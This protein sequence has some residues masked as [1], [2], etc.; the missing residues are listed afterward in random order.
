[1]CHKESPVRLNRFQLNE[2]SLGRIAE[3]VQRRI[4]DFPHAL[5]WNANSRFA[6]W[7]QEQLKGFLNIHRG[8]RCFILANGPSLRSMDLSLLKGEITFGMNRIYLLAD[9]LGFSPTYFVCIN[10]LV[11]DQ[12][13]DEIKTLMM[14]KFL[15]WNRR[16]LFDPQRKDMHYLRIKLGLKDHF[17][18]DINQPITSGG[19]VTYVALQIACY[20]GF[21]TVVLIGLDHSYEAKGIPNRSVVRHQEKDQ[22]HF[23]PNYFPRGSKWQPP[24]LI[25]SEI[26]YQLAREAFESDGRE[27]IDATSGG[28][29]PIFRKGHFES[30]I[31]R[32][33]PQEM[34]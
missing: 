11:L 31:L 26:A 6:S 19:T 12:F 5:A 25:R 29:C 15:N 9:E 34:K 3:A 7:N 18:A 32:T 2:I 1:M 20:M 33:P 8:E 21:E 17:G 13:H 30:L 16:S 24:D 27:I 23:H 14:P 28:K 4:E 10:E 22:D